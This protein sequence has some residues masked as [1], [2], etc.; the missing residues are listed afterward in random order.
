MSVVVPRP[1]LRAADFGPVV[2]LLDAERG[3][4]L[5]LSGPTAHCWRVLVGCAG[6]IAV[7]RQKLVPDHS[8]L[9]GLMLDTLHKLRLLGAS[10]TPAAWTDLCGGLVPPTTTSLGTDEAEIALGRNDPLPLRRQVAVS[11]LLLGLA[12]A[13]RV[14]RLGHLLRAIRLVHRLRSARPATPAEAGQIIAA[15][16]AAG[17][18]LPVRTA[19]LENSLATA[20]LLACHGRRVRWCL[21]VAIDPLRSHAWVETPQ[22]PASE[23]CQL[24]R[25]ATL[26]H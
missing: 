25:F 6:D 10:R 9:L 2:V 4:F 19:C 3:S 11:G 14:F 18:W 23:T 15:V 20:L 16:R 21:G 17:L 1:G 7:A 12:C 5:A 13:V 22:G 24:D 26:V 8:D